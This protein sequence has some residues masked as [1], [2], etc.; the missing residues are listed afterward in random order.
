MSGLS[1]RKARGVLAMGG[2]RLGDALKVLVREGSREV[3]DLL[4]ARLERLRKGKWSREH[5]EESVQIEKA[6]LSISSLEAVLA[7]LS[8][9]LR[10]HHREARITGV[11]LRGETLGMPFAP[12][13]W[14]IEPGATLAQALEHVW[15]PVADRAPRWVEALQRELLGLAL[16]EGRGGPWL[17]YLHLWVREPNEVG[18]TRW[19]RPFPSRRRQDLVLWG[20]MASISLFWGGPPRSPSDEAPST[21][22][23]RLCAVHSTVQNGMASLR[24]S[25]GTL[26]GF[27]NRSTLEEEVYEESGRRLGEFVP[28]FGYG[29]DR[30]DLLDLV[31][32]DSDGEPL[33]R[34]W[35]DGTLG[36]QVRSFWPWLEEV[37]PVQFLK[38]EER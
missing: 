32:F 37:F 9:L 13:P 38:L 1:R 20:E 2:P 16:L 33:V 24:E 27:F 35:S 21:D 10:P 28:F 36:T 31:E 23:S 14:G 12:N 19:E 5:F 22:V 8:W 11:C 6:L 25:G 26:E 18:K 30:M 29:D 7:S 34:H 15:K 3:V 4:V 17:G